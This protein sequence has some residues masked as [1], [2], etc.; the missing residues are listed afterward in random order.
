MAQ[1]QFA[2]PEHYTE[3]DPE[4]FIRDMKIQAEEAAK[5]DKFFQE[6][7]EEVAEDTE[8]NT[9]EHGEQGCLLYTS[10]AADE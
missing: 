9:G 7:T 2:G 6:V 5:G 8:D 10:D 1:E 3:F 4:K